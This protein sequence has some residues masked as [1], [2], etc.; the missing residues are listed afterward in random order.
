[1]IVLA[2][3]RL[4]HEQRGPNAL[5][6]SVIND[7]S[8]GKFRNLI[9]NIDAAISGGSTR[10]GQ[11]KFEDDFPV[12]PGTG[13]R[14]LRASAA[15]SNL[16][17][18]LSGGTDNT[19]FEGGTVGN[20]S[21]M[22]TDIS[23]IE[24]GLHGTK[25]LRVVVQD[26]SGGK[27]I[28]NGILSITN[29]NTIYTT[30]A[31]VKAADDLAVGCKSKVTLYDYA[32]DYGAASGNLISVTRDWQ[33]LPPAT[34]TMRS[35]RTYAGI[36]IYFWAPNG[37]DPAP[38]GTAFD[39]DCIILIQ[40]S[41]PLPFIPQEATA[42]QATFPT[43]FNAGEPVTFL[44]FCGT[45]WGGNDGVEHTIFDTRV[46]P[47]SNR[48]VL[49]KESGN[50]L[51]LYVYN[52]AGNSKTKTI[53]TNASNWPAGGLNVVA[54]SIDAANTQLLA[55]NGTAATTSSGSSGR[56][57]ALGSVISIG[58]SATGAVPANGFILPSSGVATPLRRRS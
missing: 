16:L 53:N 40:G 8:T 2:R 25:N 34:Y 27:Y 24:G 22:R 20:W 21:G 49:K 26:V 10:T 32:P 28:L 58:A 35:G 54:C 55:L 39:I 38:A 18:G 31:Y 47:G 9:T 17:A 3:P 11:Y 43:P 51:T 6:A 37:S 15:T 48:I 14:A 23:V 29:N 41:A 44:I 45:P 33:M 4:W 19:T 50:Y 7:G 42:C 52:A 1:M 12:I 36:A 30:Y 13:F 56:E 57:S 46:A 5:Y